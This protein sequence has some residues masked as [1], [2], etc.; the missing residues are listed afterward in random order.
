MSRLDNHVSNH[1]FQPGH[2]VV[3]AGH[4]VVQVG[5]MVVQGGHM[6]VQRR[7]PSTEIR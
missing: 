2:M 6:V 1:G 4:M 3:Q 7:I 5:H